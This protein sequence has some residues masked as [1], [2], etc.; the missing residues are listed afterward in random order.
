MILGPAL[1]FPN[2]TAQRAC[3]AQDLEKRCKLLSLKWL[4]YAEDWALEYAACMPRASPTVGPPQ[5]WGEMFVLAIGGVDLALVVPVWSYS[6]FVS[7]NAV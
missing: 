2:S 5:P 4:S 7:A 1:D 6:V 3:N